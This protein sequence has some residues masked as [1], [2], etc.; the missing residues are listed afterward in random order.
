MYR[1]E[2]RTTAPIPTYH[3][4]RAG[5][6]REIIALVLGTARLAGGR[7]RASR[8]PPLPEPRRAGHAAGLGRGPLR[9]VRIDVS[10]RSRRDCDLERDGPRSEAGSVR[11]AV[12][13][14]L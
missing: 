1:L 10:R 12:G 3:A 2:P 14:R 4:L 9:R 5:R 8:L 6:G 11:I 7:S 13:G